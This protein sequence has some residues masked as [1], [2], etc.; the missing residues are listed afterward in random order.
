LQKCTP[1]SS[2]L[3]A[4]V[5]GAVDAAGAVAVAGAVDAAVA[6]AAVVAA[7]AGAGAFLGAAAVRGAKPR[8]YPLK[9]SMQIKGGRIFSIR[10]LIAPFPLR[11]IFPEELSSFFLELPGGAWSACWSGIKALFETKSWSPIFDCVKGE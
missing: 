5:A 8:A 11:V 7:A 4:D 6:V 9:N 1:Q 3:A 10:P 2:W